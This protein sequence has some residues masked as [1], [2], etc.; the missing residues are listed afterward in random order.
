[1]HLKL[2]FRLQDNGFLFILVSVNSVPVFFF[3]RGHELPTKKTTPKLTAKF[4][5]PHHE[6][7]F[8]YKIMKLLMTACHV[9]SSQV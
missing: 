3:S 2:V 7:L 1:M 4:R 9:Y 6:T 5:S 8:L